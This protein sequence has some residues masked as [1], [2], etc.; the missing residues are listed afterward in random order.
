MKTPKP[1]RRKPKVEVTS[2]ID[3][4]NCWERRTYPA[5]AR[6]ES[7]PSRLATNALKLRNK[8]SMIMYYRVAVQS[9]EARLFL[10]AGPIKSMHEMI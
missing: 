6:G 2:S 8:P 5:L 4:L 1:S 9:P 3:I 10:P 7:A